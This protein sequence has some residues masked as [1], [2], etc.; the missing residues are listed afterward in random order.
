MIIADDGYK[1][2][3]HYSRAL[4]PIQTVF[5]EDGYFWAYLIHTSKGGAT[6]FIGPFS[7]RDEAKK[8]QNP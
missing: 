2:M 7:T 8:A 3:T 5:R 1:L 6:K 4:P